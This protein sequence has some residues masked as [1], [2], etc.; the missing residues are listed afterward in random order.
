[1]AT[2]GAL[3]IV[4]AFVVYG[5]YCWARSLGAAMIC[6]FQLRTGPPRLDIPIIKA[7]LIGPSHGPATLPCDN[8]PAGGSVLYGVKFLV[9]Q[10][11]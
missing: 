5:H 1:M 2:A 4:V 7:P 8:L 11:L 10:R 6:G 9:H 3:A